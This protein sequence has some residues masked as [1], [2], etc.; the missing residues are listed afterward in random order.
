VFRG[1]VVP[2]SAA[3]AA[4]LGGFGLVLAGG[5]AVASAA[6]PCGPG[7][8]FSVSGST[9]TCT[10]TTAGEDTF[11]VPTGVTSVSA[12]KHRNFWAIRTPALIARRGF[13]VRSLK[14]LGEE[15]EPLRSRS[16]VKTAVPHRHS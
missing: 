13:H 6:G 9:D 1:L 8:V 3:V 12:V 7:G 4:A 16:S 11:T 15:S 2:P 5:S 10:Y 14:G